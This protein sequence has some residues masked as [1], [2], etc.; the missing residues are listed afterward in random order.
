MQRA[1][2]TK[3]VETVTCKRRRWL[4]GIDSADSRARSAAQRCAVNTACQ[5]AAADISKWSMLRVQ[6]AVREHSMQ[7]DVSMCL[8]VRC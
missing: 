2:E 5:A 1:E 7:D 3:Y 4:P 6:Q 8:Q